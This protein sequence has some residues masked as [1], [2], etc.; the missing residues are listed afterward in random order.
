MLI[1]IDQLPENVL[2]INGL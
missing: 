2:I 1:T